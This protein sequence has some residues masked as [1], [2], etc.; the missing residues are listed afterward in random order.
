MY[1]KDIYYVE[2]KDKFLFNHPCCEKIRHFIGK[3]I[4]QGIECLYFETDNDELII[5]P[6]S[7][8]YIMYPIDYRHKR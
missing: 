3:L 5:I 4:N 1:R 2:L 8:V 6:H 7:A